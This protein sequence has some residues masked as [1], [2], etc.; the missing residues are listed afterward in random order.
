M[1][2]S[3]NHLTLLDVWAPTCAPCRAVEPII[4]D[5]ATEFAG[6]LTVIKLNADEELERAQALGVRGLPTLRLLLGNTIIHEWVGRIPTEE[7][8][9]TIAAAVTAN[10]S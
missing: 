1:E 4:H 10:Q 5:L 9:Q 3:T 6:D 8:R 2:L 7:L